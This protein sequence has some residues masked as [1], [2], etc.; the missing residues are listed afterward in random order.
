VVVRAIRSLAWSS[1]PSS[2]CRMQMQRLEFCR[3][4]HAVSRP[5]CI[6]LHWRSEPGRGR[7]QCAESFGDVESPRPVAPAARTGSSNALRGTRKIEAH[8]LSDLSLASAIQRSRSPSSAARLRINGF[9]QGALPAC[10]FLELCKQISEKGKPHPPL[11]RER[12]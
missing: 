10:D 12:R 11:Q 4:S 8:G 9:L 7:S 5:Q 6:Y 2:G 1:E 3:P